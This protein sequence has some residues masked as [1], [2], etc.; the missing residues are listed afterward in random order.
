MT[1]PPIVKLP[2]FQA[3][4]AGARPAFQAIVD[5]FSQIGQQ[6]KR[7]FPITMAIR[8]AQGRVWDAE[9]ITHG[10]TRHRAVKAARDE[11]KRLRNLEITIRGWDR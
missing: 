7:A 1:T 11:L 9:D 2:N 8:F 5:H 3:A 6:I 4:F 10:P